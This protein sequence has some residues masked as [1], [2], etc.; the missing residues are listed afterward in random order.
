MASADN[1]EKKEVV[2]YKDLI[3][4]PTQASVSPAKQQND[5]YP[6]DGILEIKQDYGVLRQDLDSS[7]KDDD[8]LP[9][10]VYVAQTQINKFGLRKGDRIEGV[11]RAPKEGERYLSL[12]RVDKVEGIDSQKARER[13]RFENLTPIHPNERIK[14]ETKDGDLTTRMIDL[15]SPV[16]KG[17]RAMIVAPPKAGKTWLMQRIAKGLAENYPDITLIVVLIGERP[18]EVT[19]MKRTVIG[20][21]WASNFDESAQEQVAVAET[22]LERAKRLAE[23]GQDVVILMDS[24]TRLARAYNM[25]ESPSG[26]TLTGGLDPAALYPPKKFFGAARNFEEGGS[27]TIIATA[28]V[29]TGSRMDDIIFEEFKGTGNMELFLDRALAERR[30]FPAFDIKLSMTRHEEL[31]YSKQE[32]EKVLT[33]RRMIDLLDDKEATQ[34]VIERMKKTKTNKE[35]LETLSGGKI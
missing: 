17:Q 2:D 5:S 27:L 16:G 4:T 7:L 19:E 33:L 31:L 1:T 6:V 30:I 26:R 13:P 28:L 29:S 12:L 3:G 24:I 8:G 35:F 18:E 15:L 22:S 14:L 20:E 34:V 23:K 21:V 32:A 11:A 9:K 10:D 25:V